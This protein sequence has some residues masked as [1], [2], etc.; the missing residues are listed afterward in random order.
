MGWKAEREEKRKVMEREEGGDKRRKGNGEKKLGR[1][2]KGRRGEEKKVF[3]GIFYMK[4]KGNVEGGH[5]MGRRRVIG[6]MKKKR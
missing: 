3:R 4:K 2:R 6:G 5:E 1:G